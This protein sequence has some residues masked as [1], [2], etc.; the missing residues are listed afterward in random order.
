MPEENIKI[1]VLVPAYETKEHYFIDLI[2]SLLKQ[3]YSNWEL[4][5]ADGS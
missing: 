1:S 3:T 4:I 5:I 2:D